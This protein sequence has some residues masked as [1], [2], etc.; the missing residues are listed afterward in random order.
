MP[1]AAAVRAVAVCA[2]AVRAVAV[3]AVAVCHKFPII[4]A[5]YFMHIDAW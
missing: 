3:R 2:V 4:L 1:S 5:T